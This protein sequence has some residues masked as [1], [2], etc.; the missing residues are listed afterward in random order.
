MR[1]DQTCIENLKLHVESM[2]ELN[3]C[4]TLIFHEVSLCKGF[5][6]ESSKQ[7]ISGF[8]DLGSLGRTNRYANHALVFIVRGIRKKYN[9]TVAYYFT[10]DTVKTHQLKQIIVYIKK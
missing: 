4:C 1:I 10:R 8:E 7:R 3:L 6:Y 5:H 9:Q 2:D